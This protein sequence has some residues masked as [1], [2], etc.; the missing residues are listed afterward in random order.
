[1]SVQTAETIADGADFLARSDFA[2]AERVANALLARGDDPDAIHLLAL[3]RIQQNRLEEAVPLLNRS[4]SVRPGHAQV[5]L[6]LGKVLA[7]LNR[8]EEA[9]AP[10]SEAA[11][12][13]PGMAEAWY[14]LGEAQNRLA[15][16]AG[17]E[18]SL[19]QVLALEPGHQLA[20]LSL[21]VVLKDTGRAA[22]AESLLAEGL[23][24]ADDPRLKAGFAYNLALAQYDQGKK[25][26]ALEN[27]TLVRRLDP[28]RSSVEISRT[29][30]L[31]ELS[32]FAEAE[33]L[34]E[35]L[36]KR[37]PL[38]NEAHIAYNDLMYRL[39]RD[40][41]FLKS[42][43]RAPPAT[44]LQLSKAGFLLKTSKLAEAHALYIG[45]LR[46]EPGDIN[47]AIGAASA[48]NLMGRH[49][50]AMAHL[51]QARARHPASPILHHH[52][53]ATALQA[54]DPQK[55]A[56]LA[57]MSL[58]LAPVD[59]YG[60]AMLGS[61]WRMMGDERDEMLNGYDELIGIYDLEPPE[62]FSSIAAFNQELNRDL[63]RMHTTTREPIE[64]SLRGG[65]QTRGN[66]FNEGHD[67]VDRLKLRITEAMKLYIA[68]I[69]PDAR[70]PFRGRRTGDFRI[71]G[72]WSSRLG[73]CGYH[74]NHV[75]PE[76]WIS[77]CYYVGVPE[78]V[79]DETAR[80]GWIKFGEP[81]IEMGLGPRRAIQPA[82]GRLVLFPSYMW[83]G[84]I[85]FQAATARTTIAFD[86]V[87][88]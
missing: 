6:N 62:G 2:S 4:L 63:D 59:H 88:R 49:G 72:S 12:I 1:M 10:L 37:E 67:L 39:R 14:E 80:Q 53:A 71:T 28:A 36:L 29:G 51:E 56:A 58:R 65:S 15:D 38:N 30:L 13:Q 25:E 33:K 43:D 21:A 84:T 19:C 48:L 75:H 55:A 64:Q 85:P 34:L 52:L 61:A 78:A 83:H 77:S 22:E 17:A 26:A 24:E 81:G 3:V 50:E 68:A 32:R 35:E 44:A 54:R 16:L 8:D 5:L 60:L 57:E 40:E 79:K 69:K 66:I 87:P 23:D 18:A 73:D 46:Y 7:L 82:P 20:K 41:D 47:A 42:Y 9:V 11:R 27:F 45:V 70:H 86:A 76:G 74:I 31:E